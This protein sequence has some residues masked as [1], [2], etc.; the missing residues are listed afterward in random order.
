MKK[1]NIICIVILFAI[2]IVTALV[3]KPEID[4]II[5]GVI[6]SVIA[7]FLFLIFTVLIDNSSD[8][9]KDEI[10]EVDR[11]L[12][13]INEYIN[14]TNPDSLKNRFGIIKIENRKKYSYDFW[15][16]FLNDALATR[17]KKFIISGK[18]LHRWLEPKIIKD[19]EK[20][21]LKL[22][23]RKTQII[24]VIYNNPSDAHKKEALQTFLCDKIYPHLIETCGK[25]LEEIN[26]VFSVYEVDSL[27]YLYTAID[28]RV[29][30]AQYFNNTSNSEN[31]MLVLSSEY[32]FASRYQ[33]DFDQMIK[34]HINNAWIQDFLQKR[35]EKQQ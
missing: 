26:K 3:A 4:T 32:D 14:D 6:T 31:I 8:E 13:E 17:T 28:S 19:F 18:T 16:T 15:V 29:V 7:S 1:R 27:S 22:I 12:L 25:D 20:T 5:S 9:I 11:K 24:F 30:V 33:D 21:L 23:S 35:E 34:G 2:L 10:K